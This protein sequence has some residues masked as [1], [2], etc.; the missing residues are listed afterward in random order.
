MPKYLIDIS[1]K[2]AKDLIS[3]NGVVE[4]V[5]QT[6]KDAR[7]FAEL[8]PI[9]AEPEKEEQPFQ[10]RRRTP[11]EQ[12][13]YWQAKLVNLMLETDALRGENIKLE[14]RLS[15]LERRV[16]EKEKPKPYDILGRT[17][18]V[19]NCVKKGDSMALGNQE[20]A[21]AYVCP[22]KEKGTT[23]VTWHLKPEPHILTY[24]EWVKEN[25]KRVFYQGTFFWC[26]PE[27]ERMLAVEYCNYLCRELGVYVQIH[28]NIY[29]NT[30][31]G[32]MKNFK[33]FLKLLGS[34]KQIIEELFTV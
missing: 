9:P 7:Y 15:E 21:A 10:L 3:D 11:E 1:E 17:Y 23:K 16:N 8:K 34:R 2:F 24:E 29:H 22:N 12:Q 26:N 32:E 6:K 13:M 19:Y 30:L 18:K 20:Y 25:D 4:F 33:Q 28:S 31:A 14:S 5:P 27:T